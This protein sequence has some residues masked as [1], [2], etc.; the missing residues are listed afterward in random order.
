VHFLLPDRQSGIH[1]LIICGIQLSTPNNLGE[2]C[3]L[4]IHSVSALEVFT[5]SRFTNRHLLTYSE[6]Q[7]SSVLALVPSFVVL[8]ENI[9]EFRSSLKVIDFSYALLG[10]NCVVFLMPNFNTVSLLYVGVLWPHISSMT[11]RWPYNR[12]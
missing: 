9:L 11:L 10:K 1:C 8:A 7:K 5:Q 4:E 2:T 6:W 3:L 12:H